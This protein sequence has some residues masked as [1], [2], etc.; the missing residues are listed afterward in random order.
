MSDLVW[1]EIDFGC[2]T[3]CPILRGLGEMTGT[4]CIQNKVNPTEVLDLVGHPV[5][6]PRPKLGKGFKKIIFLGKI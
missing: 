3:V 1:V 5:V 4:S 6:K 2:F